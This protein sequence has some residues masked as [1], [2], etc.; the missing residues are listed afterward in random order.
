LRDPSCQQVS[1][2]QF[3]L[4]LGQQIHVSDFIKWHGG[5]IDTVSVGQ[6]IAVSGLFSPQGEIMATAIARV[7]D[8]GGVKLR[9]ILQGQPGGGARI[10]QLLLDLSNAHLE[11]FPGGTYADGDAVVVDADAPPVGDVLTASSLYFVGGGWS[12]GPEEFRAL[13]GIVSSRTAPDA[14]TVEGREVDCAFYPCAQQTEAEVGSIV[15]VDQNH[16]NGPSWIYVQDAASDDLSVAGPLTEVDV[17]SGSLGVL[18]FPIQV[19]PATVVSDQLQRPSRIDTI[20]KG[21]TIRVSGGPVGEILVAGRV[22]IFAYDPATPQIA[23]RL[24]DFS[25]PEI[26]VLGRTILTTE[27][28]PVFEDCVGERDQAWLFETA[29]KSSIY[30]MHAAVLPDDDGDFIATRIVDDVRC[31][32]VVREARSEGIAY[33]WKLRHL[34]TRNFH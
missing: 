29:A 5:A 32:S 16:Q 30:F 11:G 1:H 7:Q 13:A 4:A 33:G 2:G 3:R 12:N 25:R 10:G 23:T 24:A 34:R 15:V 17:E 19:L 31:C 20:Q 26:H 18:G 8:S 6:R 22:S 14:M 27:A 9:G 28:T 21:D